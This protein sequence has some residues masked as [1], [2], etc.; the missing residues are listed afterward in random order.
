MSARYSPDGEFIAYTT[1]VGDMLGVFVLN[2]ETGATTPVSRQ[3]GGSPV[4]SADGKELIYIAEEGRF[5]RTQGGWS[6]RPLNDGEP[7]RVA[8]GVVD[9]RFEAG[10]PE[11][12]LDEGGTFDDGGSLLSAAGLRWDIDADG[13]LLLAKRAGDE[14]LQPFVPATAVT[15]VLNW[16]QNHERQQQ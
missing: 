16:L 14:S 12:F 8:V 5:R 15:V 1:D 13:R 11:P 9:G 3:G 2:V 6:Y 4:W 10:Q 7:V